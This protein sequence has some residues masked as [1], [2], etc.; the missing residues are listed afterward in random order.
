MNETALDSV[1]WRLKE[2]IVAKNSNYGDAY[3]R[4]PFAS[5][6]AGLLVRIGDK[7]RRLETLATKRAEVPE[8]FDDTILDLAGYC[9]LFLMEREK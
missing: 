3:K 9:V 5:T 1:L 6:D 2:M 7:M 4:N 8:T